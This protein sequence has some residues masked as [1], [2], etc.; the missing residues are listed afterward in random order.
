MSIKLGNYYFE[1]HETAAT[2]QDKSGVY[3]ILCLIGKEY[4]V[5]DIG[6]SSQVK[7][8]IEGHDRESCWKK[9]CNG[10]LIIAVHYTPNI[11]Q[12]GRRE[13][14]QE[15]RRLFRPVCGEQ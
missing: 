6:E 4:K 13:I 9:H 5:I 12:A 11:Q 3:A 7:T 8:R 14:E 10:T 1:P 2:L 15:L